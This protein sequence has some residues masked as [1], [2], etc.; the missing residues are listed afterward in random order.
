[1]FALSRRGAGRGRSHGT[2]KLRLENTSGRRAI[3]GP[4]RQ[5]S[6]EIVPTAGA[7]PG[8]L[9]RGTIA[10]SAVQT[11]NVHCDLDLTSNTKEEIQDIHFT[12]QRIV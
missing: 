5:C 2:T 6:T 11:E 12:I 4:V 10:L 8:R 7:L 9:F 1:M 3:H